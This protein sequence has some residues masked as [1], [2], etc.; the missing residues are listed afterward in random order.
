MHRLFLC[1]AAFAA[2]L[3]LP[4]AAQQA[5]KTDTVADVTVT[6][7]R[8]AVVASIDRK[9]YRVSADLAGA[10]GSI[11]DVLRNLPSVEVDVEGNLSI[12]GDGDVQILIDGKRSAQY[13]SG[14]SLQQMVA[15]TAES[16]EVMTNPS[17]EFA[18]DG[19]GGIINIITKV[20]RRPGRTGSVQ[21]SIGTFGKARLAVQSSVTKD[22]LTVN[23]NAGL[24]RD[25]SE[26][27]YDRQFTAI[28]PILGQ[29]TD[30]V[31]ASRSVRRGVGF[32]ASTSANYQ[33]TPRDR[34]NGSLYINLGSFDIAAAAD[35]TRIDG[36]G[37]V[38][39]DFDLAGRDEGRNGGS[40]VTAGWSH[41]FAR[42]GEVFT[43]SANHSKN[44][45]RGVNRL[46]YDYLF[47][48]TD[49]IEDREQINSRAIDSLTASYVRPLDDGGRL[50]TGYEYRRDI[51]PNVIVGML[52]D[53]A[54]NETNLAN[55]TND[56]RYVE[57]NHQAYA[58]W[59]RPF[60][61]LTVLGGARVELALLEYDQK[62][63]AIAGETEYADI[64][65]SLHLQ[66]ALSEG[67]T[68]TASYSHRVQRP[69]AG[70]LNPFMVV[71]NE[72]S[73]SSG[74]PALRPQETHSLEAGWAWTG[75]GGRN[76]AATLYY[77]EN[78]NTIGEVSR[79]LT[80]VLILNTLENQGT[81]RSGGV[82]LTRGGR[83]GSTIVY[84]LTASGSYN[85]FQRSTL[86][87]GDRVETF[88]HGL[89]ATV[90]WRPT[91]KDLVQLTGTYS[92]G[93]PTPQGYAPKRMGLNAGYQRKIRSDLLFVATVSDLF[94]SG[95]SRNY[96]VSPSLTG[97]S[98]TRMQG[99]LFS[100]G[101]TRALGGRQAADGQFTYEVG[102]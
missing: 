57:A 98:I 102:P 52:I 75:S 36:A 60:G 85:A 90:D 58:T 7:Q 3:A 20:A 80:P 49:R 89:R 97:V 73:A 23:M 56:F 91:E 6:G 42:A 30:T 40:G 51:I 92:G 81:S 59:Q 46:A 22:R 48:D 94:D 29:R 11:S 88:R 70:Q 63:G 43:L 101:F 41:T 100:L 5:P 64:H 78:Y 53:A 12:R 68:L 47:P 50:S 67:Q 66:Y 35:E 38:I 82:E 39:R 44:G 14:R 72:F 34:L 13:S 27:L 16:I 79:F 15:A 25:A 74:N 26:Q 83:A 18:P 86:A 99:R 54:G 55:V 24:T 33:L 10:T 77:R 71:N 1:G 95:A 28:D 84:R 31:S 17:A 87:G 96:T 19:T 62:V 9:T 37:A 8:A 21:A 61:K 4:A 65:P 93:G 2:L 69:Q 32:N 45:G 76:A